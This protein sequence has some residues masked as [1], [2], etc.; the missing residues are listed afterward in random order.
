[1]VTPDAAWRDSRQIELLFENVAVQQMRQ[2]AY[3]SLLLPG[4]VVG[5]A[6]QASAVVAEHSSF[7][8][9]ERYFL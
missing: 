7:A 1:M 9:E 2:D 4:H 3:V 5:G 8:L 6:L